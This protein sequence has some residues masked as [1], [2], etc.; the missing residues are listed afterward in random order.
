MG[1]K[2]DIG[3]GSK[4]RDGCLGIDYIQAPGVDYVLDVTRERFPF[5]DESVEYIY[6]SHCLEHI[7]APNH[8]FSEI[9]RVCCDHARIEMWTPYGFSN[10]AFLYGHKVF[11]TEEI[12][13]NFCYSYRDEH[14]DI[15]RGRWLLKQVNYVVLPQVI[16]ELWQ[17]GMTVDFGIKYLKSVVFEFGVEIEFRKALDTLPIAPQRT[18]SFAREGQRFALP[19]FD[20]HIHNPSIPRT[21]TYRMKQ[22]L[23][24]VF[25]HKW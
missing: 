4:K 20:M 15:L 23:H 21:R 25:A 3:C 11:L 1:L 16:H 2:I 6:S 19:P 7:E 14:L 24:R 8:L 22:W 10:T 18:Y 9:A 17:N 12:W 5:P 13:L